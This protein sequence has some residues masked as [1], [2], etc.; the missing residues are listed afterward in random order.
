MAL[1]REKVLAS[2][3]R[4]EK[5]E[6]TIGV[7]WLS[8]IPILKYLFGTTTTRREKVTVCLTVTASVL[9]TA[10]RRSEPAGR[11]TRMK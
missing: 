7:P 4:E 6:E 8:Q 10:G 5:V 2:W 3:R 9:D 11:L 1:G